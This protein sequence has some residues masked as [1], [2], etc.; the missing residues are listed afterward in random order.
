MILQRDARTPPLQSERRL[1]G[2]RQEV[3]GLKWSTDHQLLASG[4]NDNKVV[5]FFMMILIFNQPQRL[6]GF[7]LL[8]DDVFD[9]WS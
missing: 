3:C 8:T 4:G 2:H 6:Y 1:Q 7:A 9:L 5:L